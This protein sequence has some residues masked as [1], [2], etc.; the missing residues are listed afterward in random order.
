MVTIF[1]VVLFIMILAVA[2]VWFLAAEDRAAN[3]TNDP[4]LITDLLRLQDVKDAA[5]KS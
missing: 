3:R 4:V 2:L 5:E 1:V